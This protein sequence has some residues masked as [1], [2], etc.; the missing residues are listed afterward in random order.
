MT[1]LDPVQYVLEQINSNEVELDL[2][3]TLL[4]GTSSMDIQPETVQDLQR[5]RR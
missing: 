1:I 4:F 3:Q 5:L 2:N